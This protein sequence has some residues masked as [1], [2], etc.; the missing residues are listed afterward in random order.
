[1]LSRVGL[2]ETL[3]VTGAFRMSSTSFGGFLYPCWATHMP[4]MSSRPSDVEAR[5]NPVWAIMMD[6]RFLECF[7]NLKRPQLIKVEDG[8]QPECVDLFAR[9]FACCALR[10]SLLFYLE[11]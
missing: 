1:M 4:A 9:F 3:A 8:S 11:Q 10:E 7:R 5:R 2:T 6:S